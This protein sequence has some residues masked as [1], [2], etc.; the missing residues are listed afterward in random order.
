MVRLIG[1]G[2]DAIL[3]RSGFG[4]SIRQ[5]EGLAGEGSHLSIEQGWGKLGLSCVVWPSA[6][7]LAEHLRDTGA[8]LIRNGSV[9][10]LGAGP[11]LPGLTA[12][13]L[14]ARMVVLTDRQSVLDC[15]TNNV[16]RNAGAFGGRD[17]GSE[18]SLVTARSL[19]WGSAEDKAALANE[20]APAAGWTVCLGSDLVY[21]ELVFENLASTL[22]ELCG[23]H[24]TTILL[25]GKRRYRQRYKRFQKVLG[26]YFLDSKAVHMDHST[27]TYILRISGAI[28]RAPD[29]L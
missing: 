26:K 24:M 20:I 2:A 23:G 28:H 18:R 15:T 25:A 4:E 8:N 1:G 21:D 17:E 13:A 6:V 12:A 16:R 10:E 14:G 11:G 9:L 29:E 27:N 7:A 5:F 3:P 22:H 19:D